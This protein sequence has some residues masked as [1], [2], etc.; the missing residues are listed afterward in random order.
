MKKKEFVSAVFTLT[1]SML[2]IQATSMAFNVFVSARIG[3]SGMGLFHLIMSVYNLAATI[4]ISGIPLAATRITSALRRKSDAGCVLKK[5]LTLASVFGGGAFCLL[6]LSAPSI[7]E[8][9]IKVP[10]GVIPLRI[11]ACALPTIAISA[12]MNGY[13][14]GLQKVS[15]ITVGKM[16]EEFSSIFITLI[17][18]KV[19]GTRNNPCTLLS[20]AIALSSLLGCI[21]NGV[22]CF[23]S[24]KKCCAKSVVSYRKV[25]NVSLPVAAGAYMRSALNTAENLIIPT[26]LTRSGITDAL[27]RYG[28][29]KGMAIPVLTF[30]Y[31][32]LQSLISL[33]IPEISGRFALK[34]KKSVLRAAK[35]SLTATFLF[36]TVVASV[37]F[38]QGRRLG[39]ALY[40]NPEA[41]VYIAALSLLAI[42]MY[43]DSVTDGILKG[44]NQ[45]VYCLKINVIDSMSRLP[46]IWFVLPIWGVWGYIAIMYISELV[47]LSLSLVRLKK[48]LAQ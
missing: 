16:A 5:C 9:I 3:S 24:V 31:V 8:K 7:A 18:L 39:F 34:S 44:L 46:L 14:T 27:S 38:I 19:F 6:Y 2:I 21:L 20:C 48:V 17:L 13:F 22:M 33:L 11:L 23:L 41:G 47:N 12:A 40:K 32:F 28:T 43:I 4:A 25:L 26:A 29:L 42:P 1:L 37:L 36:G 10:E 35:L 15:Y 45:Q 30:P